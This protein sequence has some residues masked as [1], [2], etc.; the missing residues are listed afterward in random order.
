VY[1]TDAYFDLLEELEEVADYLVATSVQAALAWL[2]AHP[3]V[4]APVIGPRTPE[5]LEENLMAAEVDMPSD[6]FERL[7]DLAR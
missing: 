4:T 6:T 5:Q 7:A 3:S 1:L 2:L